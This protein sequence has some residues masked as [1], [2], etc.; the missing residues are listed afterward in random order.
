MARGCEAAGYRLAGAALDHLCARHL[1]GSDRMITAWLADDHAVVI[2]IGP[3]D[4]SAVDVYTLLLN[5]LGIDLP[6]SERSTPPC[7]D[8]DGHPPAD[9]E[10]AESISDAVD[11]LVRRRRQ[12]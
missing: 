7:C 2:A 10:A 4:Q 12:H 1:Y 5:A 11:N 3:H 8:G 6:D 9:Q